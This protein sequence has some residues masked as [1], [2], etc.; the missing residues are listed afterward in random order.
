MCIRDR[1]IVDKGH[2]DDVINFISVHVALTADGYP[3]PSNTIC[4]G[5]KDFVSDCQLDVTFN[6]R[7]A[8]PCGASQEGKNALLAACTAALN[9]HTI[10]PHEAGLCSCLLYTSE[11]RLMQAASK[12]TL[13]KKAVSRKVS[14]L[15]KRFNAAKAAK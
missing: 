6:G 11:K 14:R 12:G 7:A 15:T 1:S 3:L 10:A 4:C 2:L 8:H 13:N 5:C 9:I